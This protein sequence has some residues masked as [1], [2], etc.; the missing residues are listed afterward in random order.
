[1]YI[2]NIYSYIPCRYHSTARVRRKCVCVCVC[3]YIFMYEGEFQRVGEIL[4]VYVD[5]CIINM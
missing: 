1:M 5:M 3:M 2:T 4:V